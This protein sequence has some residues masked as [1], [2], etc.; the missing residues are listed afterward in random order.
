MEQSVSWKQKKWIAGWYPLLF[1]W[2]FTPDLDYRIFLWCTLIFVPN[3]SL[4]N[5]GDANFWALLFQRRLHPGWIFKTGLG[6]KR[7]VEGL[8]LR[9]WLTGFEIFFL[10]TWCW[11]FFSGRGE[12][13]WLR[14]RLKPSTLPRTPILWGLKIS[15]WWY[16][17]VIWWY[18]GT[19]WAR[20]SANSAWHCTTTRP[21]I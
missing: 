1:S 11:L 17:S 21:L 5:I 10:S 3:K 20:T 9:G 18:A 19:T 15:L 8:R 2:A 16:K 13:G 4:V 6:L 12:S 14:W 7:A